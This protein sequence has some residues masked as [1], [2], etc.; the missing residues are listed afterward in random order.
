MDHLLVCFVLFC[1]VFFKFTRLRLHQSVNAHICQMTC[2]LYCGNIELNMDA[3]SHF[4]NTILCYFLSFSSKI[5][6]EF[7]TYSK[8]K[9]QIY[10]TMI[11]CVCP[12]HYICM[13]YRILC[14]NL[15][16]F[17]CMGHSVSKE[18][19]RGVSQSMMG[20][21]DIIGLAQHGSFLFILNG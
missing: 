7:N 19:Q 12:L 14:L 13:K 4:V 20:N 11:S 21:H 1:F 17:D 16:T 6:S 3:K 15:M 18:G 10:I 8:E 2:H 9:F 5:Y